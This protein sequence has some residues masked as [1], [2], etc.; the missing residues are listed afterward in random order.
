M[1][2]NDTSIEQIEGEDIGSSSTTSGSPSESSSFDG[3]SIVDSISSIETGGL[4]GN[5]G[6]SV[7]AIGSNETAASSSSDA[8]FSVRRR[9][10]MDEPDI[11]LESFTSSSEAMVPLTVSQ[12]VINKLLLDA[13]GSSPRSPQFFLPLLLLPAYIP[14]EAK[15]EGLEPL[16]L[17]LPET[18]STLSLRTGLGPLSPSMPISTSDLG[19]LSP[20]YVRML[21]GRSLAERI[22]L[23]SVIDSVLETTAKI[24]NT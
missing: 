15:S 3:A 2:E 20:P 22:Q 24:R 10:Q 7:L 1:E 6:Q 9:C 11:P 16:S 21:L 17:S 18:G 12:A 8:D 13:S 14:E 23:M 5:E 4:S 19:P